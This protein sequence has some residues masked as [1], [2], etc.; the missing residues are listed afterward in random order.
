MHEIAAESGRRT[1]TAGPSPPT[2]SPSSW[3]YGAIC[4]SRQV[5]HDRAGTPRRL[6]V[7]AIPLNDSDERAL[8]AVAIF[9]KG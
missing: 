1:P 4:R 5:V 7:T 9:W 2:R 8:G 6:V 3:R